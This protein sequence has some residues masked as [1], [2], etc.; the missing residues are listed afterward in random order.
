MRHHRAL[1]RCAVLAALALLPTAQAWAQHAMHDM[2]DAAGAAMPAEGMAG[3][4]HGAMD[5][6]NMGEMRGMGPMQGG[7][8]PPDARDPDAYADGLPAATMHG[9]D[10]ADD[11]H[12]WRV[13]L[14]EFEYAK[15]GGEEGQ[16]L[17]MEA[18]YGG[19]YDKLWLKAEGERRRGRLEDFRTELLWDHAIATFWSAQLGV[20]H[21][22]GG[23]PD[24][25]WLAV[26]VQ[27]LA[28]YWFET[29]ATAYVGRDGTVAA[30][31][32]ARHE[33]LLT[34]KWILEPKLEVNL[35]SKDD[36]ER[37]IGSGLSDM[38]V[39]LRLR[40]E[41]SREFAPYI[42]VGWRS[43]FGNTADH[44]READ[45]PVRSTQFVAGIR[46]WF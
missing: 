22:N 15:G 5:H 10:M 19:D 35:Y 9:M 8:A 32:E 20:R 45:E 4:D 29:E 18:W 24:R 26:G 3:M 16:N 7:K 28:P 17:G 30:R 11:R 21:D 43:K 6:G 36:P 44:A 25:T 14:N 40:Y 31:L 38:E 27:G 34:Q 12:H 33:L 37:G 46:V 2:K 41:V 1:A 13:L 39:G 42:G 23:G